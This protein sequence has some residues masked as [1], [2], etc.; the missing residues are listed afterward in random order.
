MLDIILNFFVIREEDVVKH[1]RA[2]V[3][4]SVTAHSYL[5]DGF[6][7]DFLVWF[8][9]GP[10]TAWIIHDDFH[11]F[12]FV[13][14]LRLVVIRRYLNDR[15]IKKSCA[16][17]FDHCFKAILADPAKNVDFRNNRT[18]IEIRMLTNNIVIAFK[19]SLYSALALYYMGN[20]WLCF[21]LVFFC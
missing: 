14:C 18:M 3:G 13:K 10:A 11:I 5:N 17:V 16:K 2:A 8:P 1:G 12:N 20:Y 7:F 15:M 6:W 21:S 19:I 4:L 9:W